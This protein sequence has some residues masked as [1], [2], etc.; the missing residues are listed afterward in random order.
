MSLSVGIVGLPNVGKST[1]FNALLK[2]QQALAA[3]YPFATIEP[4]TGIVEVPDERLKQLAETV[5]KEEKLS[6]GSVPTKPATIE[7]VDIAGLVAGAAKGEGLGNQFLAH[8]RECDLICHV[9]RAFEDP[10]VVVTGKLNPVEDLETVRTELILKDLETLEN[11][12]SKIKDPTLGA[13]FK[14]AY[15]KLSRGLGEGKMAH[16]IVLDDQERE[17]ARNLFLLTAKPEIFAV[18]VG[19]SQ[20][21]TAQ[22][23]AF[24]DKLRVEAED[25]VVICAKVESDLAALSPQDQRDYLTDLGLERSGIERMAMA[26][27]V[28]LNLVSFLTA[29]KIEARAWTIPSGAAAPEAA[30]VIHSDFSHKFISAKVIEWQEFVRL[31]GWKQAAQVG[32]VRQEG[33]GYQLKDGEVVEFAIG[34]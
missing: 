29:G 20:I 33:R 31:G 17:E 5:E 16:T 9:L 4:N 14:S 19:E 27:Y 26:A 13:K 6:P 10:D 7:F 25:V 3:N 1:L 12:S 2:R 15:E 21:A 23:A 32:K 28:K 30:G 18:N 24:A 8:I 11:Q 22:A 34:K